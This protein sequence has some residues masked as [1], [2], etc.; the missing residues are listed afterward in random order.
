[1]EAVRPGG[2][3]IGRDQVARLMCELGIEGVSRRRKLI[4]TP[5]ADRDATRAPDMVNR[6]FTATAPTQL[7]MTDSTYVA[8]RQRG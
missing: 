5:I 8:T 6:N 7:W 4:F 2:H 1:M 3:E